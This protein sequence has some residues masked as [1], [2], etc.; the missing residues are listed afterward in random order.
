[1]ANIPNF[2]SDPSGHKQ[3]Q[4]IVS[5]AHDSIEL[6]D[7]AT[8]VKLWEE[9]R[10]VLLEA[11]EYE[12]SEEVDLGRNNDG[13]SGE[14]GSREGSSSDSGNS[15]GGGSGDERRY[16]WVRCTKLRCRKWRKGP[17]TA[18]TAALGDRHWYCS[19]N[20]WDRRRASC[21]APE[22]DW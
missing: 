20:H 2:R 5:H 10:E 13:D 11:R 16:H 12:E 15:D 18:V 7:I 21:S 19:K 9:E 4:W 6:A 22:E 3:D 1:M 17:V 8:A 14:E